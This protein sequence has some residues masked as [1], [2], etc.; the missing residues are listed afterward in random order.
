ME[1][2]RNI[3]RRFFIEMQRLVMVLPQEAAL[4]RVT[5]T[6]KIVRRFV[7]CTKEVYL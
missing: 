2:E 5:A 1:P 4:N 3:G 7:F 6:E